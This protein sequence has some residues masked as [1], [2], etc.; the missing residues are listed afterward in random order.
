VCHASTQKGDHVFQSVH[1]LASFKLR[2]L[3][4]KDA[5]TR[6]VTGS[7]SSNS[8][9]SWE[10]AFLGCCDSI[11]NKPGTWI[12]QC[13]HFTSTRGVWWSSWFTSLVT[14][15]TPKYYRLQGDKII[16]VCHQRLV[17]P[18]CKLNSSVSFSLCTYHLTIPNPMQASRSQP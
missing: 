1:K 11:I 17:F 9:I 6:T 13:L 3:P 18:K 10:D 14:G 2:L 8:P 7:E 15:R 12:V 5:C 16:W 4:K